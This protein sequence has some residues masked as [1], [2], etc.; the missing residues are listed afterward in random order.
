[1]YIVLII[2]FILWFFSIWAI[3]AE[4]FVPR[5]RRTDDGYLLK[6]QA[7]FDQDVKGAVTSGMAEGTE[8]RIGVENFSMRGHQREPLSLEKELLAGEQQKQAV[9]TGLSTS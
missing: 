4:G 3:T 5:Q 8:R 2:I 1:L 9:L 7:N 6:Y